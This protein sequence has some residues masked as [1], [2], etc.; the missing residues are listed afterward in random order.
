MTLMPTFLAGTNWSCT[1]LASFEKF[2]MDVQLVEQYEFTPMQID[3]GSLGFDAH[4]EVGHGG[5]FLA[6]IPRL[7]L[8]AVPVELGQLR[9]V[10]ARWRA[11]RQRPRAGLYKEKLE[12]YETAAAP[13][14]RDPRGSSRSTWRAARSS[15]TDE[16]AA[17]GRSGA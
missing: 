14:R 8:P 4:Q 12:S 15:A 3:A 5:R 1:P 7:L 11:G 9:P 16:D 6:A 17:C 10:D 13:E 2:V